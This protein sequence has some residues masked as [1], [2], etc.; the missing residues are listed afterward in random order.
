ML[1]DITLYWVTNTGVSASRFYWESHSNFFLA[2]DVSVPA[3]VSA[4][5]GENYQAPK[6]WTE[7]A[8]HN[9][10]YFNKPETGGHFAAWEQ[11]A[12]FVNEVRA[13]LRPLRT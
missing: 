9:L 5:P 4:F 10:I 12:I 7:K 11:P 13:G 1:D 8:Y 3:A 6:S 2:G